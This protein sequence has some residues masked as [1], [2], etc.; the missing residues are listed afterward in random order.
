M[1]SFL[2][3]I[4]NLFVDAVGKSD[5]DLREVWIQQKVDH[6][7]IAD[8]RVF[9]YRYLKDA[10][11]MKDQHSPIFFYTGNEGS[12]DSFAANTGRPTIVLY[13]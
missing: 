3:L 13:M 10:S 9:Q 1:I 5:P 6:F 7:N 8:Q 11:F 2:I 4:P 12:I